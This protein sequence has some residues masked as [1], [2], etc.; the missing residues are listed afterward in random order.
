MARRAMTT[1]FVARDTQ[2]AQ[3]MGAL[4]RAATG[5]PGVVLLGADAGV[6]KTRL[7]HRA[8]ALATRSGATVVTGHCVDLGEIGLPYLPFAEALG[9]LRTSGGDVVERVVAA[10]PSLGRLLPSATADSPAAVEDGANRLQLFDGIGAVLTAAGRPGAPLLLV[11]E[12]LHWADSSSRDVL[13][14]LVARM[15]D[16]HVLIVASYRTDEMHRRHPL[17][18]MIAEMA[19]H[20]NVEHLELPAFTDDE[21]RAFTTA[22]LGSPLPEP[23]LRRVAERSEGNAYFAEELLEAGADTDA[24]PGTLGDVLRARL[25]LLDPAVQRLAQLASVAG[26]RVSEPLLRAVVAADRSDPALDGSVGPALDTAEG[27][28]AALRDAVTHHVLAGEDGRI[29]FRH[30]LL[31][32][33]VYADLLPGEQVALH[34]RYAAVLSADPS[35]GPASRLALHALRGHDLP[36]ALRASATAARG[37]AQVLAPAEELRH[38]ETVLQVWEAVPGAADELGE[39]R[40]DVLTTAAG[41]AS[42]AGEV[43]R[44]VLLAR[45]AVTAAAGDPHRQ[46]PLRTALARHLMGEE[47]VTEALEETAAALTVLRDDPPSGDRAWALA[48][49]ARASLNLDRD[50]EATR[51]ATAAIE[52]ARAAGAAGAEADALTT[53][54][55]LVVDDAERAA[56]LLEKARDR[57][58]EAGDIVTELRCTYNL[59]ATRYY[60]G[61]LDATADAVTTGAR[62]A[63]AAG[64]AWS[65]FGV[66]LRVF[67]ELIRYVHGDL[68]APRRAADPAPEGAAASLTSV[69][70]YAAVARGDADAITRGR[71][72]RPTW[73]R[74]GQI[75]LIS[76]GCTVDALAW[77]GDLDESVELAVELIDY[78]GRVWSDYFLGGIWIAALAIAALA[79][80]AHVDRLVGRSA[81]AKVALGTELLDRAVTT[82]EKG[83]PR[84]GRLGPE[85][86]AW[87]ARAH[88]EH[89]RLLGVN[90]PSLWAHATQSFEYGYR[91]EE[92]RSR[93]RWAQALLEA[94]NRDL[95]T[96]HA[97]I[98]LDAAT[99][100]GAA[101][102]T[103][104]IL[105][106]ARRGRLDLPGA[107]APAVDTLTG[108]E[109]EVLALVAQG[110]TNRQVGERLFISGKTV[111]VHVSNVLTKLGASGRTEAVAI[112]HRRGLL[113]TDAR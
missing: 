66:E 77:Q 45:E 28:D 68:S 2:V 10:R 105:A 80:G 19:R 87:L 17:R 5:R 7:L 46:A 26:R 96:A 34:R 40:I 102:L 111:S 92:T 18:P 101:P 20:P 53:L 11:I 112:A 54:A 75:A 55:V 79:D 100:M 4:E 44:A 59:I 50:D 43:A 84:G 1:P 81:A 99:T 22:V 103:A 32:E 74:D 104:A 23:A 61:D 16:E 73:H 89:S 65:V 58:R 70:L 64:L 31:A 9:Q 14:F 94:G 29:V 37:A 108:R 106:L 27:F 93:W 78:L 47:R 15:R 76:G 86:L 33:A 71:A 110:L 52:V 35:L 41:A 60:A 98:A 3:L 39:D 49:H 113:S 88:A 36:T 12:D 72:L 38:L 6:G 83:R 51:A 95:A 56:E 82:A 30:A 69:E 109:A 63:A 25:E 21:L 85:G 67:G 13:R 62:R 24:L 91:Y 90:D 57:A 42:R 107:R 8:A 48:T 97:Q